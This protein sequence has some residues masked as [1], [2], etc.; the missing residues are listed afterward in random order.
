MSYQGTWP[1]AYPGAV[2]WPGLFV[3]GQPQ[4]T[5]DLA[6][7]EAI[8]LGMSQHWKKGVK[9]LRAQCAL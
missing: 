8:E 6:G 4:E 2:S 1:D 3:N 5:G 9:L 7:L